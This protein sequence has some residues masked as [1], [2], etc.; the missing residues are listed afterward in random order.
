MR[1]RTQCLA[2]VIMI[3][4]HASGIHAQSQ[5]A[6]AGY[7]AL[8]STPAGAVPPI[9]KSWMLADPAI[10]PGVAV[11]TLWG[12]FTGNQGSLDAFTSAISLP[13]ASGDADAELGL[14]FLKASC[15]EGLCGGYLM[16]STGVEG[17]VLHAHVGESTLTLGVSGHVGFAKP[18]DASLWSLWANAPLSL[19][20]GSQSGVQFVPFV[21]PGFGWGQ[22]AGDGTSTSG[23]R[24]MLGGGLGVL[25]AKTGIGITIGAQRVLIDGGR[26][27]FGAGLTWSRF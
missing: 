21:S 5:S 24:F 15:E 4:T 12:H 25:S 3:S 1:R 9:V 13:F 7:L 19:A 11:E 20:I 17:R 22:V 2:L 16:A 27:L 18:S 26:T 6:I 14:G 8:A 23:S 10:V